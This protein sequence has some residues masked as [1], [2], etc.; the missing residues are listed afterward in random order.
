MTV[1]LNDFGFRIAD[2][3]LITQASPHS[4]TTILPPL[5]ATRTRIETKPQVVTSDMVA[6]YHPQSAT[7]SLQWSLAFTLIE[8]CIAMA[9][10]ILIL[11]VAVLGISGIQDEHE[12]RDAAAGIESNARGMLLK[13]VSEHRPM[14]MPFT[15]IGGGNVEIKRYGEKQ[16]RKPGSD[17]QWEFSP[18]GICEPI[19]VR[20]TSERG[21][22]E[23]SFDPLTA[24]ARKKNVIVNK[25]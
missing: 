4:A 21:T 1:T 3:G 16:Y 11:T 13:A 17:E 5:I 24:C 10:G 20:I 19:D 12:L 8:V 9:V 2:C 15:G 14:Q 25:T 7:R 6:D 18:T 23:M 22:I